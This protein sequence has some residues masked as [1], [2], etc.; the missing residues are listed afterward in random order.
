ML[1]EAGQLDK[2]IDQAKKTV[3]LE[4]NSAVPHSV[5]GVV[6]QDKRMY[7]DA[8]TEYK[9]ALLL[10][11]P[12]AEARGLLGYVYAISGDRSDA[13]KLIIEL[14]ALLPTNTHAALDLAVV[15]AGLGD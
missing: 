11:A 5:L 9:K 8:I 1:E 14:K 7:A 13:E 10:G 6:Y 2:A 12:P 4:P 3:D 15:F